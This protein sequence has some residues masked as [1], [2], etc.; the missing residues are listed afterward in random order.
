MSCL[1]TFLP[2]SAQPFH[3]TFETTTQTLAWSYKQK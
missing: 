2:Q 3:Q 1:T